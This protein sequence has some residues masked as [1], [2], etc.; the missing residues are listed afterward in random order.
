MAASRKVLVFG[1]TSG[2][3]GK[4]PYFSC[5]GNAQKQIKKFRE[6][7]ARMPNVLD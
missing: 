3:A 1:Y 4:W 2:G 7:A 6:T 5:S